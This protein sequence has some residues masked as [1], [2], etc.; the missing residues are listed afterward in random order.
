MHMA[1]GQSFEALQNG[2]GLDCWD[3]ESFR[4]QLRRSVGQRLRW[5]RLFGRKAPVKLE[6]RWPFGPYFQ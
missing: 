6:V 2:F 4:A 1:V 5:P 3:S